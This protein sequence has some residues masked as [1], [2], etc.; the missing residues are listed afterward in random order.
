MEP[1][2]SPS[3]G[4]INRRLARK[5][6]PSK[7][8]ADR[9]AKQ[10]HSRRLTIPNKKAP[11]VLFEG[12]Q[13]VKSSL[14]KSLSRKKRVASETSSKTLCNALNKQTLFKEKEKKKHKVW[15]LH[16]SEAASLTAKICRV[17][18]ASREDSDTVESD[19][20]DWAKS[21]TWPSNFDSGDKA[22]GCGDGPRKRPT[23]YER[24]LESNNAAIS[25]AQKRV[26]QL[27]RPNVFSLGLNASRLKEVY[28]R[29]HQDDRQDAI[30]G[31][32]FTYMWILEQEALVPLRLANLRQGL[33][34][35]E[36]DVQEW[37]YGDCINSVLMW[38]KDV[39]FEIED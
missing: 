32:K 17:A 24:W 5:V 6:G 8:T 20:D 36:L 7:M 29:N 26:K 39:E 31:K 19:S 33:A 25:A 38:E 4:G 12:F 15:Q 18:K 13:R 23:L 11:N 9:Q 1:T 2:N 37:S 35:H 27:K 21:G 14:A 30:Q 34:A 16:Q 3:A 22:V 28:E 10:K